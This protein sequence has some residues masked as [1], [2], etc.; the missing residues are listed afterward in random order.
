MKIPPATSTFGKILR[1][2]LSL[3]S[4][5]AVVRVLTGPTRGLRW[6]VGS[7]VD[8]YWLGIYERETRRAFCAAVRKDS[9][10][11]DI[12]AHAGFY[13]LLASVLTGEH[14]KVV[15]FEPCP[16]NLA[17][18]TKHVSINELTNVKIVPSAVGDVS[19]RGLLELGPTSSSHRVSNR[20][21]IDISVTSVD[22]FVDTSGLFPD[23]MKIDVEG[24][25]LRV[26][27][28]ALATI[29]SVRPSLFIAAHG[30]RHSAECLEL[31][32]SLSYDT[33]STLGGEEIVARSR[34]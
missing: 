20:G 6:I 34:R 27:D 32:D 1:W 14:G 28:G 21:T 18:L 10:V 9:T 16:D 13:T 17:Y 8:G 2:P 15:A 29:E 31:L 24:A 23:V 25:E 33:T 22:D 12:G 19:G 3:I 26:L 4:P 30:E 7:G 5:D 11:F